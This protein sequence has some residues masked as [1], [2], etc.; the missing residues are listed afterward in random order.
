MCRVRPSASPPTSIW[1]F[2]LRGRVHI[3]SCRHPPAP[4]FNP[5]IS[6]H[7]FC[8]WLGPQMFAVSY[9]LAALQCASLGPTALCPPHRALSD[10][11]PDSGK[12]EDPPLPP[13]PPLSDVKGRVLVPTVQAGQTKA[14]HLPGSPGC[15]RREGSPTAGQD[16][17]LTARLQVATAAI[18]QRPARLCVLLR[19]VSSLRDCCTTKH[20]LEDPMWE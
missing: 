1:S 15:L 8:C 10:R 9:L 3:S 14:Q 13:R 5:V 20:A 17:A 12:P 2:C 4:P 19:M 6:R 16:A 18:T 11:P 7:V